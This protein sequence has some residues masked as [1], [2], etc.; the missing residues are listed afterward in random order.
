MK[1]S[2]II[3][4][5]SVALVFMTSGL[6]LFSQ[7]SNI[8]LV[9]NKYDFVPG[10]KIIFE[11]NQEGEQNGEF[12]SRWDL[13]TGNVENA[14]FGGQNV[15]YYKEAESCIVPLLKNPEKDNLPDLFT[16]EFDCWFEPEE[17]CQYLVSF[18][19]QKNQSESPIEVE[20]LKINANHAGIPEK[21]EGFYPGEEEPGEITKGI[22]RHV[23]I[24]FNI[25][26]LKVYLDDA[27][28]V[29]IPNLGFNPSG[30]TICCDP[31]NS[32]GAEGK[33]RFI[34]TSG[35]QREL[36]GFMINSYQTGRLLQPESVLT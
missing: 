2:I 23:A 22:W 13:V 4:T 29:N 28:V 35:W 17:Y 15:I 16:I 21:G 1:K 19:D 12:P 25:R 24:S 6:Y 32:A 8:K 3:P 10:E 7:E 18:Y 30:V 5:L 14:A 36:S 20:P 31:M 34:K 33:N 9:W 11:D 27:R 26:A